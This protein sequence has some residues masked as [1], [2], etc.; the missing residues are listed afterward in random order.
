MKF[1]WTNPQDKNFSEYIR[2][3]L[4]ANLKICPCDIF[5]VIRYVLPLRIPS[6]F[7]VLPIDKSDFS[8]MT[9]LFA[10]LLNCKNIY[11]S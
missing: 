11:S 9:K 1:N 8:K 5:S 10:I 6:L 7:L 2:I 3:N 4:E